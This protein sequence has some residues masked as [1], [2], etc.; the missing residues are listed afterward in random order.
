MDIGFAA[1]FSA[2]GEQVDIS[3]ASTPGTRLGRTVKCHGP[4]RWGALLIL[5]VLFLA[6]WRTVLAQQVE[7]AFAG[8]AYSGAQSTIASRFPYSRRYE[9][10]QMSDGVPIRQLIAQQ[11]QANAPQHLQIVDRI[12]E[13]KGRDQALAVA[14]VIGN[15]T[16]SVEP[17]GSVYKLMVLVRGQSMFFDFKSMNVVRAYPLSFAYID[18]FDHSPTQSE[19]QDRVRLVYVGASGKPGILARFSDRVAHA[20]LP[21][22]VSRYLQ[23]TNVQLKPEALEVLPA[24]LKSEPGTAETWAADLISEALSARAGVPIVPYAKGYAIG[25]T[26]SM[27]ISDGSVFDLT[28]PKPDYEISA[29]ISGFKKIK[30]S[31]V[32]NGATSFVYGAYSTMRIVEPLSNKLYL[33]TGLK[34]GETR[35]IPASQRYVDDF[36]HFYDALN[37]T[38]NKLAAV[39]DGKGDEKWL[40]S[41]ASAKGI[42][43]QISQTRELFRLCK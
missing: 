6:P 21:A 29:E 43:Q 4:A 42:D 19:I 28:L 16:V 40:K 27:S 26:M 32:E 12:D 41:A 30:F 37:L 8:F 11:L 24:Y 25:N 10:A 9:Q 1:G 17:F 31:E 3:T 22:Q 33:D 5:L 2:A 7:V 14:L 34:N 35:V 15:E 36:P 13:L 20:E 38:F 39:I 18:V 23:V